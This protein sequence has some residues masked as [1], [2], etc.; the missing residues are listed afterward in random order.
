MNQQTLQLSSVLD[1][2]E[3]GISANVFLFNEDVRNGALTSLFS[4]VGLDFIPV[5]YQMLAIS[6]C[7]K[8]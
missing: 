4:K 2:L 7:S 5:G 3:I 6:Y 1:L 8:E